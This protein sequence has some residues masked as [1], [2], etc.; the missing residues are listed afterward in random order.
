MRPGNPSS[1]WQILGLHRVEIYI[2]NI[3]AKQILQINN[4]HL[5]SSAYL[6]AYV[7]MMGLEAL[8]SHC[9]YSYIYYLFLPGWLMMITAARTRI[10]ICLST[11]FVTIVTRKWIPVHI[12]S[13]AGKISFLS[14]QVLSESS[15][16]IFYTSQ[17]QRNSTVLVVVEYQEKEW[18]FLLQHINN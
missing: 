17:E 12:G 7:M 14:L 5:V 16:I 10:K 11:L 1:M 6:L 4:C 18:S 3:I 9:G 8:G 2:G 13:T 15:S